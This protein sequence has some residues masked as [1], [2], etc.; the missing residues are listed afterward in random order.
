MSPHHLI[1]PAVECNLLLLSSITPSPYCF[2]FRYS[3]GEL[4]KGNVPTCEVNGSNPENFSLVELILFGYLNLVITFR[5]RFVYNGHF[6]CCHSAHMFPITLCALERKRFKLKVKKKKKSKWHSNLEKPRI[7]SF[8]FDL[9]YNLFG[10]AKI[11]GR[12]IPRQWK[13]V[14]DITETVPSYS[15]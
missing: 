11:T 13:S 6:D 15:R 2:H 14:K 10:C 1:S 12:N 8:Y 9:T 7:F 4:L 5:C 3:A